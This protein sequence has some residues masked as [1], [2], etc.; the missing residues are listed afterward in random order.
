MSPDDAMALVNYFGAVSKTGNPGAGVTYPY[1]TVEQ[2]DARYWK[3]KDEA[4]RKAAEAYVK[5]MEAR[6]PAL[7]KQAKEAP[8]GEEKDRLQKLHDD[9]AAALPKAKAVAEAVT[10]KSDDAYAVGGYKLLLNKDSCLKCHAV[11]SVPAEGALGP[12]LI[13]SADRLRP[14]WTL[15][16]LANPTRLFTYSPLMPQN[17][18]RDAV[19]WQDSYAGSPLEQARAAR[20]VLM[21]LPRISEL[22]E[23]RKLQPAAPAPAGG[24]K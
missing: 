16:W 15:E 17:F 2:T 10:K 21:D 3:S 19:E 12:N 1:L 4:Y 5:S 24:G 11:G 20:D 22:P 8:D 7:E 14:E 18:A 9:L 6:I 23:V 13:L